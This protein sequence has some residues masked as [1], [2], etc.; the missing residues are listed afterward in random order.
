MKNNIRICV[1]L[2]GILFHFSLSAQVSTEE[3]NLMPWPK[4][5]ELGEGKFVL[6]EN[7]SLTIS[8]TFDKRIYNS[9]NSF[10]RRLDHFTKHKFF[11]KGTIYN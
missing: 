7:F 8:G 6:N 1:F 9:A 2:L 11:R 10:L 5:I 3:L 4:E